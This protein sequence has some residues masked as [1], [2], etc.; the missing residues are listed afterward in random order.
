[1]VDSFEPDDR[2]KDGDV[3]GGQGA[4]FKFFGCDVLNIKP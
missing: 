4:S 2:T 3:P 1:M